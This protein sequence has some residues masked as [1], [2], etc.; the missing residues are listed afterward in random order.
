MKFNEWLAD[1]IKARRMTRTGFRRA[2]NIPNGTFQNGMTRDHWIFD[3]VLRIGAVLGMVWSTMDDLEAAGIEVTS[4]S[5]IGARGRH[6]EATGLSAAIDAIVGE[7]DPEKK[8]ALLR[9]SLRAVAADKKA[10]LAVIATIMPSPHRAD[11][12]SLRDAL[13][14]AHDEDL[15]V[16]FVAPSQAKVKH[17]REV[18]GFTVHDSAE[19]HQL[20]YLLYRSQYIDRLKKRQNLDDAEAERLAD[21]R[22][23]FV[24]EDALDVVGWLY[25]VCLVGEGKPGQFG[26]PFM[27]A[28][29]RGPASQNAVDVM[30]H[31]TLLEDE[32]RRFV[33]K[34]IERDQKKGARPFGEDFIDRMYGR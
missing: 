1:Q 22:M 27:R 7:P 29:Q 26:R 2:A 23:Y 24:M 25:I 32:L 34:C 18:C 9:D 10:F 15:M 6:R 21:R 30:H 17:W 16:L 31:D 11:R 19:R 14:D 12:A 28:F 3:D 4:L 5:N 33:G 8:E 13:F 20:G